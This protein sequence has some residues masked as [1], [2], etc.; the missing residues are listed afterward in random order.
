MHRRPRPIKKQRANRPA[1][2][3]NLFVK[4]NAGDAPPSIHPIQTP[5]P[6]QA[7]AP[8]GH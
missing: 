8:R 1:A 7:Q 2:D 3:P 5:P 4:L 6:Q